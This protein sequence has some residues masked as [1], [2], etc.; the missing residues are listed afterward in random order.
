LYIY[1]ESLAY[2]RNWRSCKWRRAVGAGLMNGEAQDYYDVLGVSSA[3]SPADI[4]K[5][6]RMLQKKHHPDIAG[7]EVCEAEP[8]Q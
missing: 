2:V 5:A 7:A 6:Y 4:R 8:L 1:K 3:A